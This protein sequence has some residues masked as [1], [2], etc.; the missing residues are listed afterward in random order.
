MKR[1][2]LVLLVV[3]CWCGLILAQPCDFS[4]QTSDATCT[5]NHDCLST[6]GCAFINFT[7]ICTGWYDLEAW[8]GDGQS[9]CCYGAFQSCVNVYDNGRRIGSNCHVSDCANGDCYEACLD[10]VCLAGGH[11]YQLYVC[12]IDCG[13][14]TC[15]MPPV[16]TAYGRVRWSSTGTCQ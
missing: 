3:C 2:M 7:P 12:L 14:Q 4:A 16:C 13:G 1:L 15:G 6:T 9:N 11:Q 8:T 5:S 10:A